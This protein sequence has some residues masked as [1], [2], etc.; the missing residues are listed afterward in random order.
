VVAYAV[1]LKKDFECKFAVS[2]GQCMCKLKPSAAGCK[3]KTHWDGSTSR[4]GGTC[5]PAHS[6]KYSDMIKEGN[7]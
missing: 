4:Y 1:E 6:G 7:N 3:T 5:D 2:T